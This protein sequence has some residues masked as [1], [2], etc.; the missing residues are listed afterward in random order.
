M[1]E[2]SPFSYQGEK[3]KKSQKNNPIEI[4]NRFWILLAFAIAVLVSSIIILINR[5]TPHT[6]PED[7]VVVAQTAEELIEEIDTLIPTRP[8][9]ETIMVTANHIDTQISRLRV[10]DENHPLITRLYA[11]KSTLF[12]NAGMYLESVDASLAA[13][14]SLPSG[15][16]YDRTRLTLYHGLASRFF[17]L[18]DR[19]REAETIRNILD[20]IHL[21]GN[22]SKSFYEER[23]SELEDN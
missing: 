22:A 20:L 23:L 21:D 10:D 9:F 15:S 11:Q 17:F 8:S 3:P 6:P 4:D 13:L 19:E 7:P 14:A 12:Y 5:P 1:D 2:N 18:D 16:E